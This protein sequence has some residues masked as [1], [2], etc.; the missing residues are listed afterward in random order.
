[1]NIDKLSQLER[2]LHEDYSRDEVKEYAH[3]VLF[4]NSFR[5]LPPSE[6]KDYFTEK[7]Q[8]GAK[9]AGIALVRTT[10]MFEVSKY[11]KEHDD[12]E[13]AKKCRDAVF[14]AKGEIVNFPKVS[15]D[16]H[17]INATQ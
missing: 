10:D 6:R 16:K 11:L 8:S 14:Q 17:A 4:G 13:F 5:L 7:C 12:V 1:M 9:R 15:G 2:N 3:G